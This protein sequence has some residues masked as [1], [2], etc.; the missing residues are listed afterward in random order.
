MLGLAAATSLAACAPRPL[1]GRA[2]QARGGPLRS[3]VREA[4]ARVQVAF[5]GT[6]RWRMIFLAPDRYAWTIWTAN[7]P[8]H[9]VFDGES[10]RAFIGAVAVAADTAAVPVLRTHARFTAVANLDVLLLPGVSVSQLAPDALPSETSWG[11]AATFADDGS[12]YRLG[13]DSRDLLVYVAGPIALPPL[14]PGELE[15]RYGDFRRRRGVL[16]PYRTAYAFGGAGL[17]EERA[18]AVCP[19]EAAVVPAWFSQPVEDAGCPPEPEELG[20]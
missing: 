4:E 3:V 15:V 7:E 20:H 14:E 19:N 8:N 6:W 11:L 5:P 12:R 17:A 9:Y 13:F 2:I 16:V 10:G 1:V 18:L